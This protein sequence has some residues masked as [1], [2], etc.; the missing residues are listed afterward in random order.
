MTYCRI[1][2]YNREKNLSAI[3]DSSGM[4]DTLD[5]FRAH[6]LGLGNDIISA[7]TDWQFLDG[8]INKVEYDKEHIFCRA[9]HTGEPVNT[10]FGHNGLTY[11]ALRVGDKI[12]IP[13][14]ER[15]TVPDSTIN[16]SA[17]SAPSENITAASEARN[18]TGGLYERYLR[19]KADNPGAIVFYRIGDFYEM[20]SDDANTASAM[21]DLTLTSRDCGADGRIPICGVP[22]HSVDTYIQKLADYGFKIITAG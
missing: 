9:Y 18:N 2:V 14:R 20:F 8:N 16:T 1:T 10:T 17:A 22:Y 15:T 7:S 19:V 6:L 3:F 13:D 4:Y 5:D 21:L 12:Y 11:R